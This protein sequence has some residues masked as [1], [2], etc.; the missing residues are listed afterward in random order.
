MRLGMRL[1]T[2]LGMRL[3]KLVSRVTHVNMCAHNLKHT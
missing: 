2:R 1:G 3:F